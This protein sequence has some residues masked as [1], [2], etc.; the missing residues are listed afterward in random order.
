MAS[1]V[2]G[3]YRLDT[4]ALT[5]DLSGNG[6]NLSDTGTVTEGQGKRNV[7]A[8]FGAN[9][10]TKYLNLAAS[11]LATNKEYSQT[12][13]CLM[14]V[15]TVPGTGAYGNT[16]VVDGNASPA[17][18]QLSI[19]VR[20]SSGKKITF[21]SADGVTGRNV[22]YS[23]DYTLG[24]WY[25]VVGSYD[26]ADGIARLYVD[27]VFRNSGNW[28]GMA[29]ARAVGKISQISGAR[30][31]SLFS[32]KVDEAIFAQVAWGAQKIKTM[33]AYYMGMF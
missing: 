22:D 13:S 32:G 21:S 23:V 3:W 16:M 9:N 10:T 25:Y 19:G 27:G 18:N 1:L 30:T 7:S 6:N 33:Y 5:V 4:G 17:K 15:T 2:N 11:I 31:A 26:A 24:R 14:N 20:E 12:Y 29:A 8:D 28:S